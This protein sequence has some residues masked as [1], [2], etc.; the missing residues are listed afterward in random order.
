MPTVIVVD[1]FAVRVNIVED[2]EGPHVHVVKGG[3][4]YRVRLLRGDAILLTM[5]GREKV[6]RAEA[7]RAV[8]IVREN[9][10]ACW[11]EWKKW[12]E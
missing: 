10:L 11:A 4:E 7:R 3:R 8:E 9:L 1:G 6:T 2:G 5:G 12:H